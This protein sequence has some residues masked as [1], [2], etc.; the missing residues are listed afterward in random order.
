MIIIAAIILF[1][2]VI[3]LSVAGIYA[4]VQIGNGVA[5][6]FVQLGK[7]IL[8]YSEHSK[9]IHSEY[10]E[11]LT[12]FRNLARSFRPEESKPE[13]PQ[14]LLDFVVPYPLMAKWED[15]EGDGI[16]YSNYTFGPKGFQFVLEKR[17]DH[18]VMRAGRWEVSVYLD[19]TKDPEHD[20]Y[21]DYMPIAQDL[22]HSL[23]RK[24]EKSGYSSPAFREVQAHRHE[25]E[26][27][28]KRATLL[29]PEEGEEEHDPE[30]E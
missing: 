24:I 12:E 3:I 11:M 5:S 4:A 29:L 19:P 14:W 26:T 9:H 22:F 10:R 20:P 1:F 7:A 25:I 21:A 27:Y 13:K 23:I 16:V 6:G 15:E 18:A 2:A 17:G 8:R 30:A 28:L